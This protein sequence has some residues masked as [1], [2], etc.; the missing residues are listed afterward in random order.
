VSTYRTF[1]SAGVWNILF[2]NG[3]GSSHDNRRR[4]VQAFNTFLADKRV[5]FRIGDNGTQMYFITVAQLAQY[6]H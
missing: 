5:Q 1:G 2:E 3:Y 4:F 6:R